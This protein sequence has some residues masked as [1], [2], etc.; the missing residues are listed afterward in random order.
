MIRSLPT[1]F[2]DI[3]EEGPAAYLILSADAPRFTILDANK[4]YLKLTHTGKED[5]IGKG[6]FEIFPGNPTELNGG[7]DLLKDSLINAL[8][9]KEPQ[10]MPMHRYDIFDPQKNE[11]VKKYWTGINTPILADDG[12]VSC[13]IHSPLDVTYTYELSR[14]EKEIV[15]ALHQQRN[16]LFAVFKYAP[17]GI[18]IFKEKEL[19]VELANDEL[20]HL[21]GIQQKEIIGRSMYDIMKSV[22]GADFLEIIRNSINSENPFVGYEIPL[23]VMRSGMVQEVYINFAYEKIKDTEGEQTGVIVVA[24][25]VST[26]VITRKKLEESEQR[27]NMAVTASNMG[28]WDTDLLTRKSIR[29]VRHAQIFGYPDN[30]GEWSLDLMFSHVLPEDT[31]RLKKEHAKA[32]ET[33]NFNTQFRIKTCDD[34]VKWLHVMGQVQFDSRGNAVRMLGT[35]TDITG[36]KELEKLK[37]EFI[38]T[39]SHEIKTP[40]TSIKAYGQLLQRKMVQ[41]ENRENVFF[42]KKIDVQINRLTDLVHHLLD[43]TRI[44]NNKLKFEP[45][46]LDLNGLASEI[47]DEIQQISPNHR[48]N[49]SPCQQSQVL[50]DTERTRQVIVNML[51]NAI[52]YSPKAD[53]IDIFTYNKDNYAHFCVRDFGIGIP[54]S[55]QAKIFDRFYQ[56]DERANATPGL[57]LGLYISHQII[58]RQNGEMW[59]ESIPG[60]GSDFYFKLPLQNDIY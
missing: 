38:S 32:R 53:K 16:D 25:D 12:Q 1:S 4:A 40:V 51:T 60:K 7:S 30:S 45:I 8:A 31:E 2:A 52:K 17:V 23:Q 6:M 28:V 5:I 48:L 56:A 20:C 24:T 10:K 49:F 21:L 19:F 15:R 57:G 18:G 3:F 26:Q 41:E 22:G 44:D 39:V 50:A 34:K 47:V 55:Q 59:V 43:A 14:K 46:I 42:L 54:E 33:G 27:L 29:S 9:L 35:A 36:N 11:Y 58:D 37:D 13:I